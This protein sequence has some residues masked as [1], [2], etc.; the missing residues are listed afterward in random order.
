[1]K[2][3]RLFCVALIL[4]LVACATPPV[5][6]PGTNSAGSV[7]SQTSADSRFVR[8]NQPQSL[9][10]KVQHQNEPVPIVPTAQTVQTTKALDIQRP[11]YGSSPKP[12]DAS[13]KSFS[14]KDVNATD[15]RLDLTLVARIEPPSVDGTAVQA[16]HVVVRGSLAYVSYNLAGEVFKG[17][18]QIVDVTDPQKPV[19]KA[20]M[21]LKDTDIH[22]LALDDSGHLYLAGARD[23]SD[24]DA[25][26]AQIDVI[27]LDDAGKAFGRHLK[28]LQ[29]PSFGATDIKFYQGRIYVTVGAK[30]G[31]IV[32][33]DP[34]SLTRE[35]FIALEDARWLSP[36][37]NNRLIA[38]QGNPG[39]LHLLNPDGS[40]Q[41]QIPVP[42]LTELFHKSTVEVQGE[43]AY[44]GASD[45]GFL[46]VNLSNGSVIKQIVPPQK[47]TNT[48]SVFDKYA[49]VG[50]GEDG[51]GVVEIKP[52]QSLE[53]LGTLGLQS[54]HSSNTVVYQDPFVF[55]ANGRGGLNILVTKPDEK[56]S[57]LQADV[58]PWGAK[59]A[60]SFTL[61][62]GVPA[63]YQLLMPEVERRGW[64]MTFFVYTD[65]PGW[66]GTWPIIADAHQRGHEVTAHSH[67]HSN[68]TRQSEAEI[69][70]ELETSISLMRQ[71]VAPDL[72]F[73][74]FAY[75]YEATDDRTWNVVKNYHRYARAGDG[76][77]PVPPNPVPIND[78]RNPNFGALT[79]KANTREF[80][81]NQWNSWIDATVA[82]GG[83]FIEEWHGVS[84]GEDEPDHTGHDHGAGG[85]ISGG[86]EPRT[87]DEFKQHFDHIETYH[88]QL[89]VSPMR[90]VGNYI[91]KRERAVMDV[92]EWSPTGVRLKIRDRVTEPGF[93]V[94]LTFTLKVPAGWSPSSVK[95]T[96]GGQP[97]QVFAVPGQPNL[98]R[99]SVTLDQQAELQLRPN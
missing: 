28:T 92:T 80:S 29:L 49:F 43:T 74:S 82:S 54:D 5:Q 6:S 64:R 32:V 71:H 1:M 46:A 17:A 27:A 14:V 34:V 48:V 84:N 95:A 11:S 51:I 68:M 78:A 30:D 37:G 75:P 45:G 21:L 70:D 42:G 26:P 62:E 2:K 99:F 97:I 41:K 12:A 18:V 93:T 56:D 33:I 13:T 10:G 96:L 3:H 22:T 89:W 76:G 55:I 31:G 67:T 25:T 60:V 79:A 40:L 24:R 86:W 87:M 66:I 83:W 91:E 8:N 23:N 69:R 59:A 39:R 61:D 7:Q 36:A 65:E 94:G 98:V 72:N 85:H 81:L 38:L 15:G 47:R 19:L 35:R 50:N 4:S 73:Q 52:D 88:D 16:S 58:W 53:H 57:Y 44:I 9:A 20:E 63:P 90:I 77:V